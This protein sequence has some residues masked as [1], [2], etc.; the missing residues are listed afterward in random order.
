MINLLDSVSDCGHTCRAES[1]IDGRVGLNMRALARTVRAGRHTD[2]DDTA[3]AGC[4]RRPCIGWGR[5]TV[6]DSLNRVAHAFCID[7]NR[8]CHKS[9][10]RKEADE[11]DHTVI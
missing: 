1:L 8:L 10:N 11:V 5:T 7:E 6:R 4:A 3:W 9:Q 2:G